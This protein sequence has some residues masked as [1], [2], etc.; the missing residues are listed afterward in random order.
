MAVSVRY[1]LGVVGSSSAPAFGRRLRQLGSVMGA[2][3]MANVASSGPDGPRLALCGRANVRGAVD[4]AWWP[5]STELRTELPDLVAVLGN[6]IG[7]IR[8]VVYDPS[9]WRP[10]PSRIIRGNAVTSVD[11]YRL[12][13]R[14]TIYLAGTHARDVVLFVVPPS[15]SCDIVRRVLHTVSGSARPMSAGVLRQ[16]VGRCMPL[17]VDLADS[18]P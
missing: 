4:G 18:R 7:P 14:D 5:H 2:P 13:A 10:G 6:W 9:I 3:Y 12:V 17:A 11:P 8:R 16:L 1:A 15:T